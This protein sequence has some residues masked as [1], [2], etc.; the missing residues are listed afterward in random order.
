MVEFEVVNF[1]TDAPGRFLPGVIQLMKRHG[2]DAQRKTCAGCSV[3]W[4]SDCQQRCLRRFCQLDH[5]LA[6]LA[7]IT[8]SMGSTLTMRRE[9]KVEKVDIS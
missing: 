3:V 4:D 9:A 7:I 1:F 5:E 6:L 8:A 2:L